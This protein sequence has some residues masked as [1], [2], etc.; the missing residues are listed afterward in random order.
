MK[1]IFGING[2]FYEIT[3]AIVD[4]LEQTKIAIRSLQIHD[5][6]YADD[7]Y[8]NFKCLVT[9]GDLSISN[10]DKEVLFESKI[11]NVVFEELNINVPQGKLL[12]LS[13]SRW[14][15]HIEDNFEYDLPNGK[16]FDDEFEKYIGLNIKGICGVSGFKLKNTED[17]IHFLEAELAY[18]KSDEY[19]IYDDQGKIVKTGNADDEDIPPFDEII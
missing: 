16:T 15:G 12:V 13:K 3:Y 9:E 14:R 19:I 11:E 17:Y 7:S 18:L 5:G 10:E 1:F 4:D 2:Y 8:N 6:P